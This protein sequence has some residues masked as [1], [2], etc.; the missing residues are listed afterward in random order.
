MH[1][2]SQMLIFYLVD[3][4]G[5]AIIVEMFCAFVE[6]GLSQATTPASMLS[7]TLNYEVGEE[8]LETAAKDSLPAR[9]FL[10]Q[11]LQKSGQKFGYSLAPILEIRTSQPA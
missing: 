7:A 9:V 11:P 8:A 3:T 6:R 2:Y 1:T 5:R 10:Y 4:K